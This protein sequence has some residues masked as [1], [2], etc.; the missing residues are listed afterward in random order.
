M[1]EEEVINEFVV[2]NCVVQ[3][4]ARAILVGNVPAKLGARAFDVLMAL[5]A[6]RSRIVTKNELLSLVW[7]NLIVEE[8][9]LQVHISALR[10]VLGPL[11]IATIP[12]HGYRFTAEI[13]GAKTPPASA[14]PIPET[15][16]VSG[17]LPASASTL[18]GREADLA[19]LCEMVI[20]H[21]LTTIIGAGGIGKTRLA[22][23][24]A[25]T[26]RAAFT[27]GAWLVELAQVSDPSMIPA[28]VAQALGASLLGK[29]DPRDELMSA[30]QHRKLLLI[31][32]NCEHLVGAVSVF[33]Q[34]V[35]NQAPGVHV[36]ITSQELLKLEGEQVYR[37]SPLVLPTSDGLAAAKA[38]GAVTLFVERVRAL[39]PGFSLTPENAGDIR[40]IC[41]QLDGLPLA[42]EL[43][44]ARVP[45]LGAAGVRE[46]LNERFR[47]LTGG[48]RDAPRRHQALSETLDWSHS[49]L[50]DNERAVMRRAAVFVGG[51]G[52]ELA[53]QVLS[54][55][56]MDEWAVLDHLGT[57][58]DKSLIVAD[59]TEPPRYRLLESTRIYALAKLREAGERDASAT[60]NRHAL[61]VLAHFEAAYQRKLIETRDAQLQRYLPDI[62]NLRAALDWA[63]NSSD[64]GLQIALTGASAWIWVGAGHRAEGL[65]HCDQAMMRINATIP[66]E[67]EA[68]MHLARAQVR[69]QSGVHEFSDDDVA[70]VAR[71]VTLYRA[72]GDRQLL[73]HALSVSS[74]L[75]AIRGDF[76]AS[77]QLID[78]VSECLDPSWPLAARWYS[79]AARNNYL[80]HSGSYADGALVAEE[81]RALAVAL[82]DRQLL[83]L[84]LG[85]LM[86][87]LMQR[88]DYAQAVERGK[89]LTEILRNVRFGNV[90]VAAFVF[91]DYA[92]A[93]TQQGAL[94]AAL[95]ATREAVAKE[96]EVGT[97]WEQ[98]NAIALLAFKRGR[99]E[100]A[101]QA[102]GRFDAMVNAHPRTKI[103]L[104]GQRIRKE[105]HALLA[106]AIPAEALA[107]L[108]ALGATL[109][110]DEA[111]RLALDA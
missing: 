84:A 42:I 70:S 111:A 2:G 57:L 16:P 87:H 83:I 81:C 106:H 15:Q 6:R 107:R 108:N 51:F 25:L 88:G 60:R 58:V 44:A 73:T 90:G 26:Q 101:A 62:D 29:R 18:I 80:Y 46:R 3:P 33:V 5:Y 31:I 52:L 47:V 94:D 76:K 91:A 7:P 20:A 74:V 17:N 39:R 10:K 93:L 53:Q 34:G 32:D 77:A 9:N 1:H 69:V 89:E 102:M 78:E 68:R 12:G 4:S 64:P 36:L 19:A 56:H 38:S 67:I 30:L 96:V 40:E 103:S 79:L 49:L 95:T 98:L 104:S 86:R 92:A 63:R 59:Q 21:R 105:V 75:L 14:L 45:L 109:S 28:A 110:D 8:N 23:T 13:A 97:L 37:L 82:G 41:L 99:I 11:S 35:R 50:N 72:I 65:R 22:H 71:S 61:A 66:P 27:D 100:A 85:F 55:A 43:A 24:V 54:G 48:A